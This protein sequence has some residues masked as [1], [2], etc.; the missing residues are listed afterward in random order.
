M[1]GTVFVGTEGNNFFAIDPQRRKVLWRKERSKHAAAFRS[2]AAATP[3]AV[4]VGSRDRQLHAFDPKTGDP[5]WS[6]TTKGLVDSSPVV[7]GNRVFVG[8]RDGRV[9]AIDVKTGAKVWQFDAGGAVVASPA[10]ADGRLLSLLQPGDRVRVEQSSA[11]FKLITGHGHGYYRTLREK[12]GWG[13][14]LKFN[15]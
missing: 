15:K 5:L 6:F 12:L 14:Q 2:S 9:Y 7:V 8:S 1:G 11:R 10:V 3:E 13:G 4:I